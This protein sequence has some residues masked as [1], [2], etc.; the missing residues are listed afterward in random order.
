MTHSEC[1]KWERIEFRYHRYRMLPFKLIYSD[2]YYSSTEIDLLA[3]Y[4]IP[5][6]MW[7]IFPATLIEQRK[8]ICVTPRSKRSSF[9][10]Y[11]E[12]WKLMRPSAVNLK[13][14]APD[15]SDSVGAATAVTTAKA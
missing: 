11:R 4:I 5:E 2:G 1:R 6:D 13:A 3:A 14:E 10:K 8:V 12:A 7:Y 15:A 9:E